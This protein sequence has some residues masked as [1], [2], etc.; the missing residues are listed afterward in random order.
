MVTEEPKMELKI[1][2][3]SSETA[4]FLVFQEPWLSVAIDKARTNLIKKIL[5]SFELS[6][7]DIK[8]HQETPSNRFL[9]FFKFLGQAL[10]DVSLGL[11]DV[12]A[13]LNRPTDEKQIKEL[14]GRVYSILKENTIVQQRFS[15]AQHFSIDGD[16]MD[17]FNDLNPNTPES[18]QETLSGKGV[19]YAMQ[20][21]ENQLYT[22]L[23]VSHSLL[24]AGGLYVSID[25]N[26]SPNL[27]D[28]RTAYKIAKEKHYNI[29]RELNLI[30]VD[31]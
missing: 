10:F 22:H 17:Y 6:L 18:F 3:F 26:F 13:K 23:V 20:D 2:S 31:G 8:F 19:V 14:F 16:L 9:S 27:H 24:L 15:I 4:Y 11:E 25:F 30:N 12:T 29:F 28:F 1:R 7:N 21:S 5:K